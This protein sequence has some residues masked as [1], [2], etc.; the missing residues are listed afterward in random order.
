M[1][2]A[3]LSACTWYDNGNA[4]NITGGSV[5]NQVRSLFETSLFSPFGQSLT[6]QHA[7]RMVADIRRDASAMVSNPAFDLVFLHYPVRTRRIP[8]IALR[9]LSREQTGASKATWIAWSWPTRC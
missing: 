9:G 7:V 2:E 4:L 5:A 6:L 8:T 1:F 3:D